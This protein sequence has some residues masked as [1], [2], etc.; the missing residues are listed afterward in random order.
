[1]P[2]MKVLLVH[3][4]Y[5]QFGGEDSVVSA[6]TELLKAMATKSVSTAG[7]TTRSK[8]STLPK[9]TLFSP[10]GLFLEDQQRN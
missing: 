10:D 6:E 5:Q 7:T 3:G 9:G 8:A 2:N 4:A 1:M